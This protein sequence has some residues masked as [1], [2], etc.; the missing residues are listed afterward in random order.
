M[1]SIKRVNFSE[2]S[3][4]IWCTF[5]YFGTECTKTL[6]RQGCLE[7][8][9]PHGA[10]QHCVGM[11][12]LIPKDVKLLREDYDWANTPLC[13]VR[14]ICSDSLGF[15]HCVLLYTTDISVVCPSFTSWFIITTW[16]SDYTASK[17]CSQWWFTEVKIWHLF[18]SRSAPEHKPA[19][20]QQ[21]HQVFSFREHRTKNH[22]GKKFYDV[23]FISS[24]SWDVGSFLCSSFKSQHWNI[25]NAITPEK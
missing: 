11:P 1:L 12:T 17:C 13:S 14:L 16:S 25:L 21:Q 2:L 6:L 22:A 24:L 8:V 15:L 3:S 23:I 9:H 4:H 5:V 10:T 18:C 20:L 7:L 19:L